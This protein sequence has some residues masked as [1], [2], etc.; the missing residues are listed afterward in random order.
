MK[1]DH[2][3]ISEIKRLGK[4]TYLVFFLEK[5][6]GINPDL[7]LSSHYN[8]EVGKSLIEACKAV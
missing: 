7:L 8:F 3:R 2:Y 1:L 6:Y 5:E 4:V